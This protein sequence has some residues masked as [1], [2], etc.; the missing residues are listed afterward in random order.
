M[1]EMNGIE[2]CRSLR[3][4]LSDV[5]V[6]F[7]SNCEELVFQSFEVSPFRFVRKSRFSSEIDKVC[8]DIKIELERRTDEF[9]RFQD[10]REERI[11]SINVHQL[12][13]AEACGKYCHLYSRTRREEIK[14]R[15]RELSDKLRG[16]EF[17]QIHRSYIV[18]PYYIYRIDAAEVELDA[19]IRL[20][21]S[22]N[23]RTEVKEAFFQ[24][25]RRER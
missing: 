20:P 17:I 21:I 19:G 23:R 3:R 16:F 22:R 24:W 18:N 2:L 6:V 4:Q 15:F 11:Y 9:I 13:Y 10:D 7:I 8:K 5:L 12:M 14:I 1:Q 25:S